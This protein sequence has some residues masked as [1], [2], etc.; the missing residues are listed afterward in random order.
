M[1]ISVATANYYH[2]PFE[3]ALEIIALSG[4]RLVELDMFWERKKW[5][6]A[7]HLRGY[8]PREV[9]RLINQAGLKVSSIHD[10]GG[11]LDSP[12][13]IDGFINPQ[14]A[15][16][17]DQLGYAPDCLVFHT[18]HVEGILDDNWWQTF[19]SQVVDALRPFR[20]VCPTLTI[21][22][23][24]FFDGYY[25]PLTSPEQLMAFVCKAGLGVTLDTTHYAYIGMDI[26]Y[27]AKTLYGKVKT[28]HLSDFVDGKIHV[29]PGDGELNFPEFLRALDFSAL[30]A[31]TL[32]CAPAY[33]GENTAELGT[34]VLAERL[35]TAKSRLEKWISDC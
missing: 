11:V 19:D 15:V 16:Y 25:V 27:A 30:Q 32:E 9:V 35:S 23:M 14:L 33:L 29:F 20:R 28:I 21:E 34:P 17:L 18:P 1:L 6:M 8:A 3:Q 5:A 13:T 22:N 10:G 4:I 24:P 12:N 26:T 31:I 2:L 7:Q